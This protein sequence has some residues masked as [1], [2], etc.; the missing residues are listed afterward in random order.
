MAENH[1]LSAA[2]V[3]VIDLRA[4]FGRDRGHGMLLSGELSLMKFSYFFATVSP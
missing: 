1:G 3:L 2:P 4:I